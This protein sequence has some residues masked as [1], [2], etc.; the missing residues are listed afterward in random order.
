MKS[1]RLKGWKA[2]ETQ[3]KNRKPCHILR[4]N[5]YIGLSQENEIEHNMP[6]LQ[7]GKH[8]FILNMTF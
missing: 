3:I 2:I 1:A 4:Y 6:I 5:T 7:S 8:E